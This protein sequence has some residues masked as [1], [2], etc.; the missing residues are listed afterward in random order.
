M[1]LGTNNQIAQS[2]FSPTNIPTWE[3]SKTDTG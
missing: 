1:G 3:S 2:S